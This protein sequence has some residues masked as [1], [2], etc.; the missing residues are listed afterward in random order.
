MSVLQG[1]YKLSNEYN[2]IE[3]IIKQI[4]DNVI[5]FFNSKGRTVYLES[6][7]KNY[8]DKRKICGDKLENEL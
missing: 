1:R 2:L 6:E 5:C 3:R 8:D 4:A 7:V